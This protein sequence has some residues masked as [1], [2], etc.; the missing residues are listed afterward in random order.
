M[1]TLILSVVLCT[2]SVCESYE[3]ASWVYSP[4]VEAERTEMWSQCNHMREA[5]TTLPMIEDSVCYV[6]E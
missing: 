3:P 4:N 1:I 6:Q 5:F 2:G